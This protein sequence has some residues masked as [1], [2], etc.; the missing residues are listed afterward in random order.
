MDFLVHILSLIQLFFLV[1]LSNLQ[2]DLTMTDYVS[3]VLNLKVEDRTKG[4]L[5][6]G[7]TWQ[8]ISL[9]LKLTSMKNIM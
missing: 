7:S 4:V 1:L 9:S 6:C 5:P 8:P 2:S 3:Q